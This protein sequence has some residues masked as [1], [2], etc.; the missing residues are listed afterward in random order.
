MQA[1]CTNA[2]T[3]AVTGPRSRQSRSPTAHLIG[4]LARTRH[5][6]SRAVAYRV[7]SSREHRLAEA[8]YS[9]QEC[10]QA[11]C[12][13]AATLAVAGPRSR[14]PRSPQPIPS[15]GS[16]TRHRPRRASTLYGR[17]LTGTG[18][19]EACRSCQERMQ[20][21]YTS[22]VGSAV[23]IPRSRQSGSPTTY[24]IGGLVHTRHRPSRAVAL[25][26]RVLT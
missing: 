8:W 10:V 14:Q 23:A 18:L 17:P 3:L 1:T 21:T 16:Y 24:L 26:D 9:C 22:A 12:T 15:A 11:P 2:A 6:P 19:T 13:C 4:G 7:A 5:Q 25:F 20:A